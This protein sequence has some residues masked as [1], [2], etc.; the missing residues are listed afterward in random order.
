MKAATMLYRFCN[1]KNTCESRVF[2]FGSSEYVDAIDDGWLDHPVTESNDMS[3]SEIEAL[4]KS[5]NIGF[6]KRTSDDVLLSR[7]E[8]A[9]SNAVDEETVD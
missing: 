5:H 1:E 9:L 7:I 2:D 8:E 4:A 3:R 6:N